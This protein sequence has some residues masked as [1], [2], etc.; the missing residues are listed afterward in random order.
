MLRVE[1]EDSLEG[2][3]VNEPFQVT[4]NNIQAALNNNTYFWL[5]HD[6]ENRMM[7]VRIEKIKT[8]TDMQPLAVAEEE[9]E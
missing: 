2:V 5:T 7:L 9:D 8:I 6:K 4:M 1:L 3:M